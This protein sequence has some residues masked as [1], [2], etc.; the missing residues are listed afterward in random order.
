MPGPTPVHR[1]YGDGL[2]GLA[3]A[4]QGFELVAEAAHELGDVGTAG[5]AVTDD[6]NELEGALARLFNCTAGDQVLAVGRQDYREYD[7]GV[8]GTGSCFV[9]LEFLVQCREVEFVVYQV[10]QCEGK[11]SRD[12][13]SRQDDRQ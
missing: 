10:V 9:V 6:G 13:L 7:A 8:V 12:D 2:I 11:T 1:A 4:D 3:L 5:L